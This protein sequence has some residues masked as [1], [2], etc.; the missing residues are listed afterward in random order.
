[1]KDLLGSS[2][3]KE[4]DVS[5]SGRRWALVALS[6][7]VIVL[8]VGCSYGFLQASAPLD[9]VATTGEKAISQF[10]FS[11]TLDDALKNATVAVTNS[12]FVSYVNDRN[13]KSASALGVSDSTGTVGYSAQPQPALSYT[14]SSK[15]ALADYPF[16]VSFWFSGLFTV[17][18]SS[19]YQLQISFTGAPIS[20][21]TTT[22]SSTPQV[23]GEVDVH[24][25][26]DQSKTMTAGVS[27]SFT[28]LGANGGGYLTNDFIY[29]PTYS[30]SSWD[31]KT[32]HNAVLS[33]D[34][35]GRARLYI[36]G[37]PV[38]E[39]PA[40]IAVQDYLSL[41]IGASGTYLNGAVS[42]TSPFF[43]VDDLTVF[44]GALTSS[45]VKQ[46]YQGK[47]PIP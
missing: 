30:G 47:L 24:Y 37:K 28:A 32:W 27:G 41:S 4:R 21:A 16:T 25:S 8:P 26:V 10:T 29:S 19:S 38:A 39:A 40:F 5:R 9:L 6:V 14:Y 31:V 22:S 11:G 3:A 13:G 44:Q 35:T 2:S 15:T 34:A 1:M 17:A 23:T 43:A 46:L 20:S 18:A 36:D 12:S 45:Q 33:I 7:A 42:G